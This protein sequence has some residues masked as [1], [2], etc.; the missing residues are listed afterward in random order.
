M[1][2]ILKFN[3][4]EEREEFN[5]AYKGSDAHSVLYELD[6]W[7]RNNIKYGSSYEHETL[8]ETRNILNELCSRYGVEYV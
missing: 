3:L 5:R 7:L 4:D 2:A 1:K 6:C 8:Q